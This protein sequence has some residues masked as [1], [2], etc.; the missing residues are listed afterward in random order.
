MSSI[1][2]ISQQLRLRSRVYFDSQWDQLETISLERLENPTFLTLMPLWADKWPKVLML[3]KR[4][5]QA[6]IG[7]SGLWSR[8]FLHLP[9]IRPTC[10]R[11]DHVSL[12]VKVKLFP[13]QWFNIFLDLCTYY[14]AF[15]NRKVGKTKSIKNLLYTY[16]LAAMVTLGNGS[17]WKIFKAHLR[18]AATIFAPQQGGKMLAA[19]DLCRDRERAWRWRTL[20]DNFLDLRIFGRNMATDKDNKVY[21]CLFKSMHISED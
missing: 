17:C 14:C 8:C 15:H 16:A 7:Q 5:Q 13:L 3:P 18:R 20:K 4:S 10:P 9:Q 6:N 21:S 1:K 2:I 11:Q 12:N 19:R